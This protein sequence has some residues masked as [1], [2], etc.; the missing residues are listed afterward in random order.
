MVRP[1]CGGDLGSEDLDGVVA[2]DPE[3]L[4]VVSVDPGSDDLKRSG[5]TAGGDSDWYDGGGNRTT[6]LSVARYGG[7]GASFSPERSLTR[8]A[9]SS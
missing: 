9:A 2:I 4:A 5:E 3:V 1:H 6:G 7:G 8:L